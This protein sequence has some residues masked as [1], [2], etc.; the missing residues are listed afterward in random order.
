MLIVDFKLGARNSFV[1]GFLKGLGA[2]FLLYGKFTTPE[3]R[4]V[5]P[6]RLPGSPGS[7]WG[8]VGGDLRVSLQRYGQDG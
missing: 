5:D 7:D 1:R 6:V 8:K 3:L 2:P 4:P